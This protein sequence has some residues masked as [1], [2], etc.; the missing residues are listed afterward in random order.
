[1]W[2]VVLMF[3]VMMGC[4]ATWHITDN[5]QWRNIS[6]AASLLGIFPLKIMEMLASNQTG[7]PVKTLG[8]VAM[9]FAV[10]IFSPAILARWLKAPVLKWMFF[11]FAAVF[12][13][14]LIASYNHDKEVE[15]AWQN[16]VAFDKEAELAAQKE[17]QKRNFIQPPLS[18]QPM[19]TI[20]IP[21]FSRQPVSDTGSTQ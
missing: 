2:F 3:F 11:G 17:R 9:V 18:A 12:P 15:L 13:F 21:Q 7:A 20:H 6:I 5:N 16:K 1:M 4:W 10:L 8:W 19:S 14:A